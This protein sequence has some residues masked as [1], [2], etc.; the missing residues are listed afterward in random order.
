M[1]SQSKGVFKTYV[2]N[3][4][5]FKAPLLHDKFVAPTLRFQRLM[6][7]NIL[8]QC[9]FWEALPG[10][11]HHRFQ[12]ISCSYPW[13][14]CDDSR[15]Y[16]ACGRYPH[17]PLNQ[18]NMRS[19]LLTANP[20]TIPCNQRS[21]LIWNDCQLFQLGAVC[22]SKLACS[23]KCE[24]RQLGFFDAVATCQKLTAD[25]TNLQGLSP[26]VL[27]WFCQ[28][29]PDKWY[30]HNLFNNSIPTFQRDLKNGDLLKHNPFEES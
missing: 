12:E 28:K 11:T 30:K 22:E 5:P 1:Y 15:W 3:K 14:S 17:L 29:W 8:E 19:C 13:T 10:T 16:A 18:V 25:L 23:L 9:I 20:L 7:G 21:L 27:S 4:W 24:W 2:Q 6:L 26:R